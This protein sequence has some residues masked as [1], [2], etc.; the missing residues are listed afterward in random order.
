MK[1]GVSG[2]ATAGVRGI[3]SLGAAE[4][5]HMEVRTGGTTRGG[6]GMRPDH[7]TGT[8]GGIQMKRGRGWFGPWVLVWAEEMCGGQHGTVGGGGGG[9]DGVVEGGDGHLEVDAAGPAGEAGVPLQVVQLDVHRPCGERRPPGVGRWGGG[10]AATLDRRVC[11]PDVWRQPTTPLSPPSL[12]IAP[13]PRRTY[14]A[15]SCRPGAGP[16]INPQPVT[17][18]GPRG[19]GGRHRTGGWMGHGGRY[20]WPTGNEI[21]P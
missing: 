9:Y 11:A 13:S 19:G 1:V 7:D 21:N 10:A 5:R 15:T 16:E 17:G 20:S 6:G 3:L 4:D 12:L 14:G 18:D 2:H 8:K